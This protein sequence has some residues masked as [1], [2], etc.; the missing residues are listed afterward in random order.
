MKK[1]S[2]IAVY[3]LTLFTGS[4]YFFFWIFLMMRDINAIMGKKIF[5]IRKNVINLLTVFVVYLLALIVLSITR[6][7]MLDMLT[8]VLLLIGFIMAIYWFALIIRYLRQK[9]IKLK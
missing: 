1:R 4:I 8:F 6:A 2:P 7:L 5:D 9:V 3:L